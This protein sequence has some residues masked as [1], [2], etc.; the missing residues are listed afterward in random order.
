MQNRS[1][2]VASKTKQKKIIYHSY[3]KC[4]FNV[5]KTDK[6]M[7][8]EKILTIFI[9]ICFTCITNY[10]VLNDIFYVM[11]TNID[12]IKRKKISSSKSA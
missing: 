10:H 2:P 7:E 4:I 3:R 12:F 6:K 11:S 1:Q 8:W 5:L 9:L